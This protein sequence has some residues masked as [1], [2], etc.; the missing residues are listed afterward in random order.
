[1]SPRARQI[2]LGVDC[3]KGQKMGL[4]GWFTMSNKTWD[5]FPIKHE[6]MRAKDN[7]HLLSILCLSILNKLLVKSGYIKT[8]KIT[9]NI[10]PI[11]AAPTKLCRS[12]LSG[13]RVPNNKIMI[14]ISRSGNI[15][16]TI[17][18]GRLSFLLSLETT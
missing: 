11:L 6:K 7:L 2:G 10:V 18:P 13:I 14:G 8:V 17:N 9:D 5:R 3:E 4:Y 12:A 1:M 15:E 16:P